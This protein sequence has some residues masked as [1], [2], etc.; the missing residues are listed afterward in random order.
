M[1]ESTK[2]FRKI[3]SLLPIKTYTGVHR[4]SENVCKYIAD[5]VEREGAE[6]ELLVR[7]DSEKEHDWKYHS[8]SNIP[9]SAV[10]CEHAGIEECYLGLS[11][12]GDGVCTEGI[13]TI[14]QKARMMSFPR[15]G[16]IH[17]CPSFMYLVHGGGEE[18]NASR[19]SV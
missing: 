14:D 9:E 13:G 7:P 19:Q 15:D 10:T 5:G 2:N 6:F 16:R 18:K 8:G 4:N 11:L 17:R 1:Y 3:K 12:Y